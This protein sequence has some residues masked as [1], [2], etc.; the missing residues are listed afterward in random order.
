MKRVIRDSFKG[1]MVKHLID[2]ALEKD[3]DLA[4]IE[5]Y[6]EHCVNEFERYLRAYNDFKEE[7]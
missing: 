7:R 6:A 5:H 2:F 1:I 3:K 4:T